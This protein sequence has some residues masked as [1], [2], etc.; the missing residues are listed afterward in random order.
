MFRAGEKTLTCIHVLLI[1][2][3]RYTAYRPRPFGTKAKMDSLAGLS[4]TA[5]SGFCKP[6]RKDLNS[7]SRMAGGE[8]TSAGVT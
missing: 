2:S 6:S 1:F 8:R 4:D 5:Q 3:M 7:S